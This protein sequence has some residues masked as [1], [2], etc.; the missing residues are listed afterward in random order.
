MRLDAFVGNFYA[1]TLCRKQHGVIADHIART[2]RGKTDGFALT[3][4][5]LTFTT[6]DRDFLQITPQGIVLPSPIRKAVPDGA[7]TLWR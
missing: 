7:S 1:L 2:H 5:G 3:R 4:A 6:I